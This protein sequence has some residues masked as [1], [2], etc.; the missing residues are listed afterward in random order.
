VPPTAADVLGVFVAPGHRS[1]TLYLL[2]GLLAD[3]PVEANTWE[4]LRSSAE[5]DA[6]GCAAKPAKGQRAWSDTLAAAIERASGLAYQGPKRAHHG[7]YAVLLDHAARRLAALPDIAP[8]T[9]AWLDGYAQE[10]GRDLGVA[11]IRM[12]K[13]TI[14]GWPQV[15]GARWRAR[16]RQAHATALRERRAI[17]IKRGTSM[18]PEL[19]GIAALR[20]L[21][22]DIGLRSAAAC[23]VIETMTRSQIDDVATS[24][25]AAPPDVDAA[26]P[27]PA[28]GARRAYERGAARRTVGVRRVD[29]YDPAAR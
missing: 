10:R 19:D 15:V 28:V 25:G 14:N 21:G 18:R 7:E 12:G 8:A 22:V 2:K 17:N 26:L 4:T 1:R 27:L 3:G 5:R 9:L 24:L 6:I 13:R 29:V 16:R 20:V 23:A 11:M